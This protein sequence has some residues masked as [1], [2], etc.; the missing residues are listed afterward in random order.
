MK[1]NTE[2][3]KFNLKPFA[4]LYYNS[5]SL[6]G[7]YKFSTVTKL[8]HSSNM[9]AFED[10]KDCLYECMMVGKMQQ[11]N[12]G[13]SYICEAKLSFNKKYNKHQ[14]EA[15]SIQLEKPNSIAQQSD[16]LRCIVTESQANTLLE[17][18]PN[19]VE[20]IVNEEEI[21][22]SKTKG[23]KQF[24]FDKIKDKVIDNYVLADIITMLRPLGATMN[25]IK[26]LKNIEPNS[27]LLKKMLRDNP[28][29][30]TRINGFG[31]KKVDSLALQMN[32]ELKKSEFRTRAF[33][34]NYLEEMGSNEGNTKILLKSL[35]SAVKLNLRECFQIYQH[36]LE[37]ETEKETFLHI[38]D[39]YV[40]LTMFYSR[41]FS[42]LNKLTLLNES[43]SKIE[44]ND[45]D[46]EK[47][48]KEFELENGYKLVEKQKEAIIN[49]KNNNVEIVTGFGGTGKTSVI[50][51][52]IKAFPSA[53]ISLTALSAKA[54][55]RIIEATQY[56]ACTIHKLLKVGRDGKFAFNSENPLD[57]DIVIVDEASMINSSIFLSL[58]NAIPEGCKIIIVFDDGQLPPI[59]AG[60]IAT[61]LLK[62][63]FLITRLTQ[64]HRTALQSG[65]LCDANSIR[66]S[67]NPIEAPSR[68]L[69]R[70]E[71]KDMY[72]AFRQEKE[73][74]FE[75]T[76]TYYMKSLNNLT[77]DEIC[78]CV[79]RKK[80][81]INCCETFNGRIQELLLKDEK[82]FVQKGK[83]IF[84]LGAKVIQR[85][86]DSDKGV[87]NGET[88]YVTEIS[89]VD[90]K[91]VFKV[92]F[93]LENKVVEYETSDM[94]DL[95]L[96][97]ALTV[98]STQGSEYNTVLV[99]LDTSSYILLNKEL[100]Y[101][102]ITRAK[103]RCM[104][105]SEPKAF[106]MSI[107]N[108]ASKRDTWLEFLLKNK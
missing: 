20:M 16:F 34:S 10:E 82:A 25:T 85:V 6:Y 69:V 38:E 91:A 78:I 79:P 58:L 108:Q 49:L 103:K 95:Q 88:G 106:V 21:D 74:I 48:F 63:D 11:L 93:T 107:K 31:F 94:D 23:I 87:I 61:D 76:I 39:N 105:I 77:T 3:Y 70:G 104:V 86:N 18:Y 67:V 8:P 1:E 42:I 47:A 44:L 37:Q 102:A 41:E 97:Y 65:I 17:V 83:K 2:I 66:N 12:I 52:I 46:I 24:T 62:S 26:K 19:I 40:G 9:K 60:N 45:N 80:D 5:D 33:I 13:L 22:L 72:Y 27:V 29:I 30:L 68:M 99:P 50:K 84:K 92:T 71:L 96:A 73:E 53:S 43:T 4:E 57:S 15:I 56:P 35:E 55:Q 54:S 7:V 51:A 59:G 89:K 101:T 28:Y 36:I 90:N 100:L 64:V 32:S 14:Y 75:T 98:H 81:C